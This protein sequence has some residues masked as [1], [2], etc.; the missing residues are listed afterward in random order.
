LLASR[1]RWRLRSS[2]QT[3][4]GDQLLKQ[5]R[6]LPASKRVAVVVWRNRDTL[7]RLCE[8]ARSARPL[9][10]LRFGGGS[11]GARRSC[12]GNGGPLGRDR[13]RAARRLHRARLVRRRLARGAEAAEAARLDALGCAIGALDVGPM[14]A[15]RE[16][17]RGARRHAFVPLR[18]LQDGTRPGGF[19][20]PFFQHNDPT[21]EIQRYDRLGGL[22]HEY[23]R[24]A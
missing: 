7:S 3:R 6:V 1:A 9:R 17:T 2:R 18:R 23:A 11:R 14:R 13:G 16:H 21:H 15:V 10:P 8:S 12:I 20:G 24:A 5:A 19:K 4:W 22:I